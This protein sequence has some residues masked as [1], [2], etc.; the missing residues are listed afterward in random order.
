MKFLL[1]N[2]V[3]FLILS[4]QNSPANKDDIKSPDLLGSSEKKD[5]I[6]PIDWYDEKGNL[7]YSKPLNIADISIVR[8][9]F[10]SKRTFFDKNK[11]DTLEIFIDNLPSIYRTITVPNGI[12]LKRLSDSSYKISANN[13]LMVDKIKLTIGVN[14]GLNNSIPRIMN[15][16]SIFVNVH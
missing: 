13:E 12:F 8:F 5:T 3:L 11:I 1:L 6:I 4:C 9:R 16:D 15:F 7:K 2:I 10:K 14:Q